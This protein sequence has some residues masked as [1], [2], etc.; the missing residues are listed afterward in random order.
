[1]KKVKFLFG[2]HC[3]QPVGNFDFVIEEAY[4][5]CYLP[6]MRAM[7]KHPKIKFSA[8]YSGILYDWFDSKH[9]EFIELLKKMVSGGQL[10]IL[11]GGYYEP[12]LPVIPEADR[13]GQIK[14]MSD[15]IAKKF[16]KNPS[17]LWVTERVWEPQLAGTLNTAG[18]DYVALDDSHF[19][20][21]GIKPEDLFGYYI[22]EYEGKKLKVFPIGKELRYL[23]PF[24]LPAETISYLR[25]MSERGNSA[26]ILMDDGEKFGVWPGTHKWVYEEG[27]LENL[28][29]ALEENSSWI[30][31][32]TFSEYLEEHPPLGRVYLPTA[33][34]AE[35]IEWSKGFFRNFFVKYP[36]ANNMHKKML[37]VSQKVAG[38]KGEARINLY[39]GQ[40]NCAYW[41]GVFGGLYL[42]HL[43][44]AI[45][46]HLLKA[47]GRMREDAV[48]VSVTDFTRGGE[49][50]VIL[51]NS[52]LNLYLAP[53]KG[54][55]IFELDYKPKNFNLLNVLSRKEESY[56]R[57]IY[58]AVQ[59]QGDDGTV[60]T[61]HGELKL[62]EKGLQDFLV[63]DWHPR[64]S[65]LEHF[66]APGATPLD[67]DR[68]DFTLGRYTFY[69]QKKSREVSVRMFREGIVDRIP[70]KV[71]KTVT[72]FARQS[73]VAVDYTISN[74]GKELLSARLAVDFNFLIISDIAVRIKEK[75]ENQEK[76]SFVDELCGTSVS[77]ELGKKATTW[78]FP[79]ETV[80]QSESGLEKNY[81]GSAI[82]PVWDLEIK[83][84]EVWK[85]QLVLRIEGK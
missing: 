66:L 26:A 50:E 55:G 83:P 79:I 36:E 12:I 85:N 72:I 2:I 40:C 11:S 58:E 22:T 10:E 15:Y 61:I 34:Y 51:R 14:M 48:E 18:I 53:A 82:V 20:S 27:Y 5:K 73:I 69:P 30:E 23:I 57:K 29:N 42:V 63:Y 38:A 41:H 19:I 52:Q 4:Q 56:H 75:K 1:M 47:E 35:M 60:H 74:L 24:K 31:F 81:Q 33:S 16:G 21:A 76:I 32:S 9:P 70:V 45:Y 43:R 65:L 71:E 44:Q 28:L 25:R 39:K 46:E 3:H 7:S 49:D 13:L 84:G 77:L 67:Y 8:H 17:G 78:R 59:R 64:H 54:G 37:E 62:K 80:S 68:G 6:F